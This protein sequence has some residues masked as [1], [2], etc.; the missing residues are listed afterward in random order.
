M[1]EEAD[2]SD[3]DSESE[4]EDEVMDTQQDK[5]GS[6]ME[7]SDSDEE[8]SEQEGGEDQPRGVDRLQVANA[9]DIPQG[10]N[11][12]V[13]SHLAKEAYKREQKTKKQK[14][15][16]DIDMDQEETKRKIA[17]FIDKEED[18]LET[19]FVENPFIKIREKATR[20]QLDSRNAM[21]AEELQEDAETTAQQ[22]IY[23]SKDE[24]KLV[25]QDLEHIELEK[26]KEKELKRKRRDVFGY[27]DKEE[28]SDD[29][30]DEDG[31]R[32]VSS[33]RKFDQ[34]GGVNLKDIGKL[35]GQSASSA[36]KQIEQ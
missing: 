7:E 17:D 27:G 28:I 18:E 31:R 36:I 20:K 30:D 25:V 29:S 13:V 9:I 34:K 1:G 8:D 15:A 23:Y 16:E 33:K 14:T 19:H 12:P 5:A 10:V 22:D 6:E 3:S 24:N 2:G 11:I 21:G 26:K 32:N 4:A 35:Q